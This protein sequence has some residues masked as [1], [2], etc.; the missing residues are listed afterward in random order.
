[1][2]SLLPKYG[3][4]LEVDKEGR[5][6]KSF[7]DPTGETVPSVSEA[8]EHNGVLYLGSYYLPFLSRF[9]LYK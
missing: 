5:I 4:L 6:I 3:L 7:H 9:Y 2:M 1:M 8:E